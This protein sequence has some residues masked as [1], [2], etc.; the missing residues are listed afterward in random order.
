MKSPE[1]IYPLNQSELGIVLACG[2]PTTAYNLPFLLE[3]P[4]KVDRDRLEKALDR[5]F[6]LHPNLT[7]RLVTREDGSIG[8]IYTG[9]KPVLKVL[10]LSSLAELAPAAPYDLFAELPCRL[11]FVEA[12]GK[13]YLF[14]EFHHSVFDGTSLGLFLQQLPAL[15]EGRKVPAEKYNGGELAKQEE[16]QRAS[17]AWEQAKT[18]YTE[19]FGGVENSPLPPFDFKKDR[20]AHGRVVHRL[21]VSAAEVAAYVKGRGLKTSAFFLGAFSWLLAKMNGEKEALLATIHNGRTPDNAGTAGMFVRTLPFYARFA[22]GENVEDYVKAVSSELDG[23]RKNDL[24]SFADASRDLG[25]GAEVMFAYQGDYM[26]DCDWNG[27]RIRLI[28]LPIPEGKGTM[29]VE[30]HRDGSE[31]EIWFEYRSDLYKEET[32]RQI[33]AL[34]DRAVSEFLI[35]EKLDEVDLLDAEQLARLEEANRTDLSFRDPDHTVLDYFAKHVQQAPDHPLVVYKEKSFT[36]AEADCLTDRIAAALKSF[37]AGREKVVSV[38]IP[39]CEYTMLASLGVLKAGA[40]ALYGGG[41][42]CLCAYPG[43]R[44]GRPA[45]GFR[46]PAPVPG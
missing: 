12:E 13:N 41:R 26:F 16:K 24:Y 40:A 8:K 34:Y 17:D 36:Y 28:N 15:Y 21:S 9:E 31:F 32:I 5:F 43:P 4:K 42:G 39:K 20:P 10:S 44:T 37:G 35:K 7:S 45:A 6:E 25:V 22:A 38:L 14:F 27:T 2:Q 1:T 29:S 33:I 46:G 30:L 18:Y 23:L 19:L 3:L 11:A